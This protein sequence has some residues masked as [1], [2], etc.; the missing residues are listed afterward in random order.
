MKNKR[1]YNL[2]K[3]SI[4]IVWII[5]GLYCKLLNRVPRHETIVQRILQTNHATLLTKLIGVAEISM[6]IWIISG[7]KSKLNC[8]T[9]MIIIAIMN[10]LEFI[11]APDLLLWGRG[12]AFFAAVFILIIGLNEFIWKPTT[13]ITNHNVFLS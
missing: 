7:F 5:N 3:I 9:Q 13:F 6:A 2:I 12:N 1:I 10:F 4:A 8:L 11:I